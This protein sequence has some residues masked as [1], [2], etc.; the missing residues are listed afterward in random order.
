MHCSAV[1][2]VAVRGS[3]EA[4]MEAALPLG[5]RWPCSDMENDCNMTFHTALPTSSH[6]VYRESAGQG[7]CPFWRVLPLKTSFAS[8][9]QRSSGRARVCP[10]CRSPTRLVQKLVSPP[11]RRVPVFGQ[12]R[13]PDGTG[14]LRPADVFPRPFVSPRS[15]ATV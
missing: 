10:S 9:T 15:A 2:S 5:L 3:T 4:S 6:D 7:T 13:A 14:A 11:R 8:R 1:L 12:Q